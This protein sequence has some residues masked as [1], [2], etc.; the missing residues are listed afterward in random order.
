MKFQLIQAAERAPFLPLLA[1]ADDD[2]AKVAAYFEQGELYI[3]WLDGVAVIALLFIPG[4]N[5]TVEL[6]NLAVIPSMRRKQIATQ[7]LQYFLQRLSDRYATMVVGTGDADIGNIAFYLKNGF[8][9]DHIIKGFFLDYPA[10][11]VV[12]GVHLQDMVVFKRQTLS[13]LDS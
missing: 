9:F 3:G 13:R 8:R 7:A 5:K 11:I 2:P 12:D 4:G 6:K 1:L 10:P